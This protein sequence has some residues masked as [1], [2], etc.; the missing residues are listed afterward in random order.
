VLRNEAGSSIAARHKKNIALLR[1]NV[2]KYFKN[3]PIIS[4]GIFHAT[5]PAGGGK[6]LKYSAGYFLNSSLKHIHTR[7]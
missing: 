4:R 7:K 2:D 3:A 1:N 5:I 6:A